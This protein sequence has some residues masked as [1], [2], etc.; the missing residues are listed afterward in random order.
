ME[1]KIINLHL[2][3]AAYG[4]RIVKEYKEK[5]YGRFFPGDIRRVGFPYP[6]QSQS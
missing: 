4:D 6:G 2:L 3:D 5:M 1:G